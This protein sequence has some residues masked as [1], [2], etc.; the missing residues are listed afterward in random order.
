MANKE[1]KKLLYMCVLSAIQAYPEFKEYY[2]RKTAEGKHAF[3]VIN[4]IKNKILLRA[5]SV[6][7]NNREYVNNYKKAA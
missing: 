3:T 7:N 6:I 2:E 4:A 5:A 1:L